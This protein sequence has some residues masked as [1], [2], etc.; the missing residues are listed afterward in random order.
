M[1]S[2]P[3]FRRTIR[4][5]VRAGRTTVVV[6]ALRADPQAADSRAVGTSAA[7]SEPVSVRVGFVVSKAVGNAVI[8][9][10][11]RRRL[12]HLSRPLLERT[13]QGTCVVVRALP[14]AAHPDAALGTDL[15]GA[16]E[17]CL[18]RLEKRPER[19]RP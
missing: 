7:E 9:N 8:R 4:S 11:V 18:K 3:E 15:T 6:S 12:R 13:P 16:W 19:V 14:P 2:A 1:R 17:T 10:R 5:G